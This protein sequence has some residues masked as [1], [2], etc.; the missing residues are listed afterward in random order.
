MGMPITVEIVDQGAKK[1]FSDVFGYF[2]KIDSQYSTYKKDS[3]ISQI[4]DG[5][6][7]SKW[8]AEMKSVLGLCEQTRKCT[9]AISILCIT[10][11]ETPLV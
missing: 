8:S 3:E 6:P 9:V 2:R 7:K 11:N 5:L 4:N 10:V 1:Y